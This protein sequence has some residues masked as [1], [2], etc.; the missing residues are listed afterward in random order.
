MTAAMPPATEA[1]ATD[2]SPAAITPAAALH[3]AETAY[4]ADADHVARD[5]LVGL[6]L[7]GTATEQDVFAAI[8]NGL[9]RYGALQRRLRGSTS[10]A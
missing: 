9:Q 6:L 1:D 5:L 10:N 4:A 8:E 7:D 3:L 2:H